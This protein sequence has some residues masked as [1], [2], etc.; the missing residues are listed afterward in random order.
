MLVGETNNLWLE[1]AGGVS[2]HL[3][4]LMFDVCS[5]KLII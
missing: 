2:V 4:H 3:S 1:V 5:A